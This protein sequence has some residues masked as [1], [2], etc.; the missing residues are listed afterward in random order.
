[1]KKGPSLVKSIRSHQ[2][3]QVTGVDGLSVRQTLPGGGDL[4]PYKGLRT[5]LSGVESF[6]IRK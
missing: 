3:S 2:E 6:G 1:M 5:G 4:N